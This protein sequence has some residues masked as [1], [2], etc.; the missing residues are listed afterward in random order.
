MNKYKYYSKTDK[1]K[2]AIGIVEAKNRSIA[3]LK[4]AT[5]KDF[6]LY[7]FQSLFEIEKIS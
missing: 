7:T 1:K 5:N 2:E 4:A 6:T 3:I